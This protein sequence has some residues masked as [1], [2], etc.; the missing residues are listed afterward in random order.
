MNNLCPTCQKPM[1]VTL[2]PGMVTGIFHKKME[3]KEH[4]RIFS[5]IQMA[6]EPEI[7]D[8]KNNLLCKGCG[9]KVNTLYLS[10]QPYMVCKA[11][12]DNVSNIEIEAMNQHMRGIM[13]E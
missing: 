2:T 6:A 8:T 9:A 3:C 12:K 7:T 1:E 11:C 10:K 4:G 5:I 13:A